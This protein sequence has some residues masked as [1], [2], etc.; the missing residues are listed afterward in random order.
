MDM[1]RS[2]LSQ[3]EFFIAEGNIRRSVLLA[4]T[5]T[6]NT[7]SQA[8]QDLSGVLGLAGSAD[9]DRTVAILPNNVATV[10]RVSSPTLVTLGFGLSGY[11]PVA[12]TVSSFIF[13]TTPI[14]F[15]SL[16]N[17]SPDVKVNYRIIQI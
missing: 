4:A 10:I 3:L 14:G 7:L 6:K 5:N 1:N 11:T 15:I 2:L 17:Q 12:M 13:V 9:D 8:A 16:A